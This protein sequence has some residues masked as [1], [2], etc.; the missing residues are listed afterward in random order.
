MSVLKFRKTPQNIIFQKLNVWE[1]LRIYREAT[2]S[3]QLLHTYA[4]YIFRMAK[5][6]WEEET[7]LGEQVNQ[8]TQKKPPNFPIILHKISENTWQL[9]KIS[10]SCCWT[11]SSITLNLQFSCSKNST[12]L[13]FSSVLRHM[14]SLLKYL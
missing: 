2:N 14:L 3:A 4:F 6:I 13:N 1:P 5:H 11:E 9:K 10:N 12:R 8:Y 7:K